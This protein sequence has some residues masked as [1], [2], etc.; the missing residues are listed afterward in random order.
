MTKQFNARLD[1]ATIS[2]IDAL[3]DAIGGKNT[4]SRPLSQADVVRLAVNLL[5]DKE[6]GQSGK[7]RKKERQSA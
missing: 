3:A 5:H 1:P 6:L 4:P 7:N 2:K